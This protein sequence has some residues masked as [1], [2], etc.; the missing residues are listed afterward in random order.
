MSTLT[1]ILIVLLAIS[2]IFLCGIV[3]TYVSSATNY[4]QQNEELNSK[5]ISAKQNETNA[6]NQLN[7]EKKKADGQKEELGQQ[8]T[9][10]GTQIEKY[11]SD[12]NSAELA[13]DD[14]NRRVNNWASINQE[15]T[16][17][18]EQQALILKD[19]LAENTKIKAE[20][21]KTESQLEETSKTLLQKNGLIATL[22]AEKRQLREEKTA[23]QDIVNKSLQTSARTLIT[24]ATVTQIPDKAQP[25]PAVPAIDLKGK[26]SALDLKNSTAKISLGA[27]DGVKEK[28]VFYIWRGED[29]IAQIDIFEVDQSTA[30]GTLEL[31]QKPPKVGDIVST[32]NI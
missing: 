29:F 11:K 2:T 14:A 32:N 8:I 1:K 6:K 19:T 30:V 16:K 17:T 23:L 31:V 5:Y 9:A 15:F 22:E 26:I 18:N 3:V 7:E 28:M 13:R 24:P 27:A 10:L 12:L 21:A 20:L 4:K 25:A